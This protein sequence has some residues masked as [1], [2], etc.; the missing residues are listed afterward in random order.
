MFGKQ[1]HTRRLL[2]ILLLFIAFTVLYCS[3]HL[4]TWPATPICAVHTIRADDI[5][6]RMIRDTGCHWVVQLLDWAE[7]EPLPGEYF[8]EYPDSLVR[9]ADYYGLRLV[10]RLDHP[11]QWALDKAPANG[12]PVLPAD[13]ARFA[14]TVAR[15]YRGQVR[16]YIVWNEPNLAREW[17]G[18]QPDPTAYATLLQAAYHAIKDADPNALVV[19][20]GLA[21][22][23]DVNQQALDDRLYLR[24]LYTA[25]AAPFFDVLGAHPYGFAYP[26][27]DRHMAHDGLNFARMLD[28]RQIM[29]DAGDATKRIWATEL[30][31]TTTPV[32]PDQAWLQISE[33]QQATYLV[34]AFERARR[35]WPWLQLIAVW[36]LSAHLPTDDEKR[37]Y[38]VVN[39]DYQPRPAYQALATMPKPYPL[40][41]RWLD[42]RHRLRPMSHT[43][44]VLAPDVVVRLGDVDTFYPHWARIY[45]GQTPSR[46]WE[47]TFYAR[48]PGHG[49]WLLTMEAMQVE[50]QGN[51]VRINGRLLEPPA[52]PLRGKPDGTSNWTTVFMTVP[53]GVL[54]TGVNHIEVLLSPRLPAYQDKHAR[55]ESMQFRNVR[56]CKSATNCQQLTV[57][58]P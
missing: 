4:L 45:G 32:T 5:A 53:A 18:R 56:I 54:H 15:R 6:L 39:D 12:P 7:I 34:G 41:E 20:A 29:A 33:T 28:L 23:N 9:A 30:G 37:G 36:N 22:T 21:P 43:Y 50:E 47:G 52:I 11:P 16:A 38:S 13:Y 58:C 3:M 51:L 14:G 8:W 46:R 49:P 17:G 48:H 44:E 25:G 40:S 57:S 55:Y 26:P 10:I 2:Q 27:D 35:E 31:W 19:S 42:L 24:G 1:R